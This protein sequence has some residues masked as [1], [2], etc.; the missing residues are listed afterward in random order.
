ME[1][2]FKDRSNKRPIYDF[3]VKQNWAERPSSISARPSSAAPS[4]EPSKKPRCAQSPGLPRRLPRRS[5]HERKG[6]VYV[7]ELNPLP[8]LT[9]D[10]S[11]L[12]FISQAA[13]MDYRT[14]IA[15]ILAGASSA[16]AR[17]AARP[18]ASRRRMAAPWSRRNSSAAAQSGLPWLDDSQPEAP[19]RRRDAEE[20]A[21]NGKHEIGPATQRI[22]GSLEDV[23]AAKRRRGRG[24]KDAEPK[25]HQGAKQRMRRECLGPRL[26]LAKDKARSGVLNHCRTLS[27]L[28]SFAWRTQ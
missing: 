8:G 5:A 18:T 7:L 11:D 21:G 14:L 15:E 27:A 19:S 26:K 13:G 23:A 20:E 25:L 2:Q 1:I 12:C 10:Y 9:P 28:R 22:L 6:E 17:S 24:Q 3:E 16:C 4:F